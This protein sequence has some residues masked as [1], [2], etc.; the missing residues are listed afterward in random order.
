MKRHGQAAACLYSGKAER[1]YWAIAPYVA[2]IDEPLLEWCIETVW[3]DPWGILLT[4]STD[5]E[6]IRKHF[7]RML[8]AKG[9][10][11]P[12]SFRFYDCLLYT[13]PSPRD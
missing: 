6:S 1:D 3:S 10:D 4:G 2:Q 8:V 9:P 12:L 11:G 7:K 5:L 13:S